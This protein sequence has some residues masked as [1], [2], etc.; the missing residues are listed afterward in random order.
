MGGGG[1]AAGGGG[2]GGGASISGSDLLSAYSKYGGSGGG[3]ASYPDVDA[4]IIEP[5][6]TGGDGPQLSRQYLDALDE[7][8]RKKSWEEKIAGLGTGRPV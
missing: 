3:G 6:E 1:G 4:E 8:E 5:Y 2:G 7:R